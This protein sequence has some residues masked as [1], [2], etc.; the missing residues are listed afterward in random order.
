MK[1]K[2]KLMPAVMTVLSALY[3]IYVINS[4]TTTLVADPFGGDP[5][6]KVL[7]LFMGAF[8]FLGFLYITLT[9]R[10]DG[11]H[12]DKGTVT[13]FLLTLGLSVAY[14]LLLKPVGFVLVSAAVLFILEY[15]YATIGEKRSLKEGALGLIG[16]LALSSGVYMLFRYVTK[17]LMKL[18]RAGSIPVAFKSSVTTGVVSSVIVVLFTVL[19]SKTVCRLLARNGHK[20]AADAGLLTFAVVLLLYIVFKQFFAVNLAP[21]LLNY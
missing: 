3:L 12:A 8:L 9:E 6:G 11:K 21:G 13:L 14:V 10:P 15:V 16:T 18:A 17:T 5:G 20:R 19:F 4:E 2:F 7:P 1:T